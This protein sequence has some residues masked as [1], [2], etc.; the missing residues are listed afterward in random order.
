MNFRKNIVQKHHALLQIK[1][2][3][4]KRFK[5]TERAIRKHPGST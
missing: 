5:P 3:D 4:W 1:K 2:N